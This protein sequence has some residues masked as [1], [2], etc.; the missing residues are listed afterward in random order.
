MPGFRISNGYGLG[1]G[2]CGL[3]PGFG[4][5]FLAFQPPVAPPFDF[6]DPFNFFMSSQKV[7]SF[8]WIVD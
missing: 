8:L 7:T 2:L 3:G 6:P 4:G 5:Q 1:R